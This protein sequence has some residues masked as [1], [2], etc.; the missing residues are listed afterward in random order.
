MYIY[1]PYI[2]LKHFVVKAQNNISLKVKT[3]TGL[4]VIV[5]KLISV[6]GS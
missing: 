2:T 6:P 5:Y 3:D 1:Q 4:C